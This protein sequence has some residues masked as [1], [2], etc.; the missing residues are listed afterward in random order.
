MSLIVQLA[1]G[2]ISFEWNIREILW[3]IQKKQKKGQCRYRRPDA[4]EKYP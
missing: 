1:A 3:N 4:Y 2:R